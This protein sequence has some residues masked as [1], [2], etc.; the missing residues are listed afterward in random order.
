MFFLDFTGR[1]ATFTIKKAEKIKKNHKK[2]KKKS[3]FFACKNKKCLNHGLFGE[4]EDVRG[5]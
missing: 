3:S 1:R 5:S 4:Q 2:N